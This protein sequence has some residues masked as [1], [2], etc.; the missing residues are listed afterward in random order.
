MPRRTDLSS[1]L[2]IGSGAG[3][4]ATAVTAAHAGLSVIVVEKAPVLGGTTAWSGGWLWIPRN[5][6]ARA[7]GTGL[8]TTS[9]DLT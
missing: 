6:L 7:A 1:V 3:A 9:P 5:P 8:P 2:V 4:L